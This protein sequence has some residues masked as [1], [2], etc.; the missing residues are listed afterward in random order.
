MKD[1]YGDKDK[2]KETK[3]EVILFEYE[4]ELNMLLNK[5]RERVEGGGGEEEKKN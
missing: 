3:K 2:K 1:V 4:C 5:E